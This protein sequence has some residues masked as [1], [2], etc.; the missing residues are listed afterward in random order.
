MAHSGA[1]VG[2]ILKDSAKEG[3]TVQITADDSVS[4][5]EVIDALRLVIRGAKVRNK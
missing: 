4:E 5:D 3:V 2:K 1:V